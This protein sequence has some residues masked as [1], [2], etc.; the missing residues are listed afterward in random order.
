MK[1]YPARDV[2]S[3]SLFAPTEI[4]ISQKS[5]G[6]TVTIEILLD[7]PQKA[8]KMAPIVLWVL[9]GAYGRSGDFPGTAGIRFS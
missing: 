8:V 1:L 2:Q 5:Q 6:A 4:A 9:G 3:A 7:L